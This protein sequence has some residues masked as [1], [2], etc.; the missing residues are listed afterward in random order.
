MF[1]K[2][3]SVLNLAGILT[4]SASWYVH[5]FV[6][7]FISKELLEPKELESGLTYILLGI[8]VVW[9]RAIDVKTSLKLEEY[10]SIRHEPWK[11]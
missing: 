4:V 8:K 10:F 3:I 1:L 7:I 9:G 5:K 2:K 6:E 11:V